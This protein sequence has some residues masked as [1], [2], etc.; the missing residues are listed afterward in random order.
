MKNIIKTVSIIISILSLIFM[1]YG[2]IKLARV[3][4]E[5]VPPQIESGIPGVEIVEPSPFI[6]EETSKAIITVAF[7]TFV[8]SLGGFVVSSL[9]K[10]L[11]NG[12]LKSKKSKE[13]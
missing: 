7:T 10:R 11:K 8:I 13:S 2:S 9:K 3:N 1:L 6:D 12:Q 4:A 5:T